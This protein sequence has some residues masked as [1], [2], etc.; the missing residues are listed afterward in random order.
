ML[1]GRHRNLH[2]GI[3]MDQAPVYFA[4][5]AKQTLEVIGGKTIHVRTSTNDNK[6]ATVAVTITANGMVLPSMVI[7]KGKPNGRIAKTEF[8]TYPAPHR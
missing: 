5:N 2:F 7:F 8:A 3:N 1:I 6:R 4:M